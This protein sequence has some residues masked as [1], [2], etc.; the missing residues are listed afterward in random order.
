MDTTNRILNRSGFA[1]ALICC[2]FVS[3]CGPNGG[4]D[5]GMNDAGTPPG[6]SG[7]DMPDAYVPPDVDG[8]DLTPDTGT[9]PACTDVMMEMRVTPPCDPDT[10]T[11]AAPGPT[12]MEEFVGS[13]NEWRSASGVCFAGMET[14]SMGRVGLG[15]ACAGEPIVEPYGDIFYYDLDGLWYANWQN[16]ATQESARMSINAAH[17][18]ATKER[19]HPGEDVP[20]ETVIVRR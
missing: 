3:A 12:G 5:S 4:S 11:G 13:G 9:E 7:P 18:A 15:M 1:A 8:G 6:D 2:F 17:D 16:R 10:R 20:Y 19:F 14:D